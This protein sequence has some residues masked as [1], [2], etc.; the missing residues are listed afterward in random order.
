MS[1][2]IERFNAALEAIEAQ[3]RDLQQ[4]NAEMARQLAEVR[5]AND[6]VID[7]AAKRLEAIKS[8]FAAPALDAALSVAPLP[9]GQTSHRER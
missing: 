7:E 9:R 1:T 5:A 2:P 6:D 4:R 3:V 8:M